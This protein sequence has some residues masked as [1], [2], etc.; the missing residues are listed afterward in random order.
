MRS[1]IFLFAV[2]AFSPLI[3]QQDGADPVAIAHIRSEYKMLEDAAA[4]LEILILDDGSEVAKQSDN[5][6]RIVRVEKSGVSKSYYYSAVG[7]PLFLFAKTKDTEEHYFF[8][9]QLTDGPGRLEMIRWV[10]NKKLRKPGDE[11]FNETGRQVMSEAYDLLHRTQGE[12]EYTAEI[13]GAI[14]SRL[15]Q[16]DLDLSQREL[17]ATDTVNNL[18]EEDILATASEPQNPCWDF[19]ITYSDESE[20]VALRTVAEQG[21]DGG[22]MAFSTFEV[23]TDFDESGK[24]IRSASITNEYLLEELDGKGIIN[25]GVSAI[26]ATYFD[27]GQPVYELLT[28]EHQGFEVFRRLTILEE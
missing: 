5:I 21:C 27:N 7:N 28:S 16:V 20:A 25:R 17:I 8:D 2:S 24:K 9:P 13:Y 6:R 3:A 23:R 12:L 14:C 22:D 1:L 19:V 18:K 10:V 11:A 4:G 15:A 26:T